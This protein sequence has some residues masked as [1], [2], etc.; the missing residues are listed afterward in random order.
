MNKMNIEKYQKAINEAA[1]EYYT[2][3]RNGANV[4]NIKNKLFINLYQYFSDRHKYAK[5]FNVEN[6]L[7]IL[8]VGKFAELQNHC[9]EKWAPGQAEFIKY[10]SSLF[11]NRVKN[12]FHSG[13]YKID[14]I[15]D[16]IED[17]LS[18][19][20]DG[21]EM[22]EDHLYYMEDRSQRSSDCDVYSSI[23]SVF[24]E[25]NESALADIKKYENS[26]K[27]CYSVRFFTEYATKVIA[28]LGYK[29]SAEYIP[30]KT[31]KLIDKDFAAFYLDAAEPDNFKVIAK[32]ELRPLSEFSLSEADSNVKCGYDL[33]SVVYKKYVLNVKGKTVS[34]AAISQNKN[35]FKQ[36]LSLVCNKEEI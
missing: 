24:D 6:D 9:L 33:R 32:A 27:F 5:A 3:S 35:K 18:Y 28:E 23:K 19:D 22:S 17:I 14:R 4:K 8:E 31:L 29:K 20:Q 26:P 36:R 15:T 12:Q 16:H 25:L 1:E 11:Y 21:S 7:E 10:F 13:Q 34:D 30:Q 2:L